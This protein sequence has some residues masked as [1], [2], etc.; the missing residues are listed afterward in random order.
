MGCAPSHGRR[1]SSTACGKRDRL[2]THSTMSSPNSRTKLSTRRVA[3]A[4]V[5]ERADAEGRV[6]L[7]DLDHPPRP[8]QQRGRV[9]GLRLDVGDLVAVDRVHVHRQ[10]EPARVAGGE[11]GVAVGRPL[12]RGAH[13]VAV[14]EPDVVAHADL[15][16]VVQDGRAGQRQQQRGEQLDLV[17]VVLEQRG[18]PAADA[19][20]GLHPRVARV[21][22]PHVV[23][24]FVGD[25][26]EG[27]LVVVAQED[28]PLAVVGDRRRLL[29]DLRDRVARSRG[30]RP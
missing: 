11:A 8:V 25:H 17:D 14:T 9:A 29:H 22:R 1:S 27:Q 4:E 6:G 12:H 23:A 2:L 7:A 18:Q 30:A 20:V 21:L 3:A 13:A 28:A 5:G 24:L 26:L 19:D 15:V 16:A 10:V